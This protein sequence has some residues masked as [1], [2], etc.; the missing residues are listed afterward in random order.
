MLWISMVTIVSIL[1][2][3]GACTVRHHKLVPWV[4]IIALMSGLYNYGVSFEYAY[5]LSSFLGFLIVL[6]FEP[7]FGRTDKEDNKEATIGYTIEKPFRSLI[8][9]LFMGAVALAALRLLYYG[10]DWLAD[11]LGTWPL[12]GLLIG[13][14]LSWISFRNAEQVMSKVFVVIC[15]AGAIFAINMKFELSIIPSFF[16][17]SFCT[18]LLINVI[19]QSH[20]CPKQ[21][22]EK[23]KRLKEE[24]ERLAEY[25]RTH[26]GGGSYYSNS[27]SNSSSSSGSIWGNSNDSNPYDQL[28]K[29]RLE[30]LARIRSGLANNGDEGTWFW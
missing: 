28:A 15:I 24:R 3:I 4:I 9:A 26:A 14:L 1:F 17:S 13:I 6:I 30:K 23:Q 19:F 5:L 10:I 29:D 27:S 20:F 7:V 25:N 18:Y 2:T 11:L 16:I 22:E 12:I 21:Y 8:Y